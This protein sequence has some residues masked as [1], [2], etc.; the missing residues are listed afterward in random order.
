[1]CL[2][3]NVFIRVQLLIAYLIFQSVMQL[4][5]AERRLQICESNL[6][7]SYGENMNRVM[8]IK[9]STG[10]EKSLIMRLHLLQ[11]V[12]LFHQNRRYE[13]ENLIRL[14]ETELNALKIDDTSLTAL[15]EMGY[16]TS[17]S[18]IAL[19]ASNGDILNAANYIME[20]REKKALARKQ[21]KDER[22]L[23]R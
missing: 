5:D 6:Q 22:N 2:I 16:G 8:A 20:N 12:V 4:P 11:A 23:D 14:A 19:R 3:K 17:E 15:I 7:K 13:A 21:G 1:M 18:R 10:N 9:G